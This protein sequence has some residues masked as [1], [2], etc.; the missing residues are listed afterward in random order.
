GIAVGSVIAL[1]AL[2]AG[3][4][5][6]ASINPARSLAPALVSGR[7]RFPWGVLVAP[8]LRGG[9]RGGGRAPVRGPHRRPPAP[10]GG[11]RGHAPAPGPRAG[12]CS[13]AARA[14]T[15]ARWPRRRPA[16]TAGAG[17]S[18]SAPARGRRGG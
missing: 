17:S 2:F 9:A 18:R 15:V 13:G 3:P 6:G 16:L 11:P 1:E 5:S 14:P 7:G 4:V 10:G 12:S 8:G